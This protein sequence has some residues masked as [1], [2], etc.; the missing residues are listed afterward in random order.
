MRIA[1]VGAGIYG[2]TTAIELIN[3]KQIEVIDLFEEQDDIL[4]GASTK[5][6]HRFHA[7]F[8]YPRSKETIREILSTHTLFLD[9]YSSCLVDSE[10]YYLIHRDSYLNFR[11]YTEIYQELKVPFEIVNNDGKTI[12]ERLDQIEGIIKTKE[13]IIDFVNI[14]IRI[15]EELMKDKRVKVHLNNKIE[16]RDLENLLK[17][18]DW[19]I[20]TTYG[21]LNQISRLPIFDLKYELNLLPVVFLP[22]IRNNM[23]LTVMDGPFGSI[24]SNGRG[25]HVLYGVTSSPIKYSLDLEEIKQEISKVNSNHEFRKEKLEIVFKDLGRYFPK[26]ILDY[27]LKSIYLTGK[28]KMREDYLE[29]RTSSIKRTDNL[30][31]VLSGKIGS[32]LYNAR[33]IAEIVEAG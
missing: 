10:N 11:E 1:I 26:S 24:Y 18:Y 27:Q 8:H 7:G 31:S 5:N 17:K 32:S 23:C 20:N 2:L 6:H 30:I 14:R 4:V 28:T 25:L 21:Y 13:L 16:M 19:V 9:K 15:I 33:K 3:N 12:N 29:L 22:N